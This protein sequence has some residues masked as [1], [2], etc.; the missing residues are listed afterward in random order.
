MNS[1]LLSN[2]NYDYL[3]N[4]ALYFGGKSNQEIK[5]LTFFMLLNKAFI[6]FFNL[7]MFIFNFKTTNNFN[8]NSNYGKKKQEFK[9]LFKVKLFYLIEKRY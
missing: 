5:D 2:L 7:G 8:A 3:T 6:V 9:L 4:I 1:V